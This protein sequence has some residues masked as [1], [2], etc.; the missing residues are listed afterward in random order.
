MKKLLVL[1]ALIGMS[2]GMVACSGDDDQ[3]IALMISNRS[4]EF[5]SVLENAFVEKAEELG[6]EVEVYDA[7]NDATAQPS[8]VENAIAKGVKAIVINPLNKD[9]T[10]NVLND[11]VEKGIPVITVDT[12]VEGV[13]LL[14]EVATDNED[15][16]QFAAEWLV[17]ES[18]LDPTTLT[19]IVHMK[20]IDGH[21]A[22]IARYDGFNNYMTSTNVSED[23]RALANNSE[24]YIELTGNFAQDEAQSAF[25]SRLSALDTSGTYAVYCEN[26]VMAIGVIQAIENDSRF[27]LSNFT[28]IGFDGSADGKELVDDGKMAVTVVQD[29]EFIGQKAAMILDDYFTNDVELDDPVVA[30]EVVMYPEDEN[31]RG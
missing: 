11:A 23:W 29:F 17:S 14:A 6:Y 1:F 13:E 8:Q 2:F 18:G 31:P 22:H 30:I 12:T 4:N 20:G 25:E 10:K 15:G 21:T 26:D 7:A 19:G 27:D 16:G 3:V 9:A 24:K 5:F 28:I